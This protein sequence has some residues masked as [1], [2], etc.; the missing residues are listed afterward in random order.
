MTGPALENRSVG[1]EIGSACVVGARLS[2]AG[3]VTITGANLS[4]PLPPEL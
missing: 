3:G 1:A 4:Q 2:A